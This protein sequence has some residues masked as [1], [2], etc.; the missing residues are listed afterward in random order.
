[1]TFCQHP[2]EEVYMDSRDD[3]KTEKIVAYSTFIVGYS[4]GRGNN[5]KFYEKEHIYSTISLQ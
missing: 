5:F 3:L 1:M 4:A 2:D